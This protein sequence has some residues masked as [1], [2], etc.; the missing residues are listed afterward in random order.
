LALAV[1]TV[2]ASLANNTL[3]AA[4]MP[5]WLH[6]PVVLWPAVAVLGVVTGVLAWRAARL[7]QGPDAD[8]GPGLD[9]G[10]SV[11]GTVRG[12]NIQIG[13]ARD[14]NFGR[15]APKKK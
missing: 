11:S 12:D 3:A 5:G 13:R 4:T 10:Q 7:Q 9:G 2:V 14:V 15:R 6:N 8:P 1:F